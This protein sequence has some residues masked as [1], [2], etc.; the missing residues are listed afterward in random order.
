VKILVLT[1]ALHDTAPGQRFRI[2]Q[3]ARYLARRGVQ[4]TFSS[5]EDRSLHDR[6]YATGQRRRKAVGVLRGVARRLST[7]RELRRYDAVFLY[8]EA[9]AIGPAIVER[10]I[11]RSGIPLIYDFDDPIWIPYRSPS[12]GMWSRLKCPAKTATICSLASVVIV[13]NRLLAT[14]A[15]RFARNVH[16][17]PS[18]IDLERYPMERP[19]RVEDMTTLGWTGS[20]STLPF[21]SG[22]EGALKALAAVRPFK[23]A[24]ISNRQSYS[25]DGLGDRLVARSWSAESEAGDL[26]DVEIGLAPFPS[27]GW[28]PWRCHGKVLQYMAVG[29]VPVA[30][31]VGVVSDYIDDGK[32]GFLAASEPEWVDRLRLLIDNSDLRRQ[33][34]RAAR[35]TVESRYS[36]GLWAPQVREIIEAAIERGGYGSG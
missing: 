31:P 23:L 20:H 22:V 10:L 17:V 11:A 26:Q 6:L 21:L 25:I 32:N 2:E 16:V 7:L 28:T 8:R 3:W 18:T 27:T 33:M 35:E 34:G 12:N 9:A 1:P 15:K 30:S 13:G 29:A 4:F 36:A 14:Y 19:A 5:F 24:V